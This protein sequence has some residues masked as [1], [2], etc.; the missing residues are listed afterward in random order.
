MA[1]DR[2]LPGLLAHLVAIALA[3]AGV[4]WAW[5]RPDSLTLLLLLAL[6]SAALI[7]S[8]LRFLGRHDRDLM[9]FVEAVGHG[10][11]SQRFGP[12]P[13]AEALDRA[14]ARLRDER[15]VAGED[16]RFQ[17]ALIE[18]TPVPLI[19]VDGDG[20]VRLLN[21]A[22]RALFR[23]GDG[24]RIAALAGADSPLALACDPA[25]GRLGRTLLSFDTPTGHHRAIVTITDVIR[26]QAPV[27]L[28]AIAPIG[29]ELDAAEVAAQADLVRVLT[30]EIMNSMTPITSLARSAAT[31]MGRIAAPDEHVRDARRAIDIVADRAEGLLGFVGSYRRYAT[32]PLVARRRFDAAAWAQSI[33]DLFREASFGRSVEVELAVR[34]E[35]LHLNADPELLLQAA[36]N[37]LKN[38]AEAGADRVMLSIEETADRVAIL[39]QD[40]GPGIADDVRADMFLP[41]FTSK[42]TGTGIGLSLARQVAVA[43]GGAIT[44][45]NAP[46][47]GALLRLELW[48][49]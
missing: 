34:P 24:Q 3:W 4:T 9:R 35:G 8:L 33:A 41:F 2:H 12:G 14:T 21:Q 25:T 31:L 27:R 11:L 39:V 7:I 18:K 29:G 44:A 49:D 23:D 48:R 22:A 26:P 47:G 6:L 43:H 1:S 19:T 30:H 5:T 16:V 15:Q 36:L 17:R 10:D 46:A 37:L 45:A 20:M 42:P 13:V 40:N 32:L 38:A 28:V